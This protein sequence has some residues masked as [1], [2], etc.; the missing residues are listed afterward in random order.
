MLLRGEQILS[1]LQSKLQITTRLCSQQFGLIVLVSEDSSQSDLEMTGHRNLQILVAIF[2]VMLL[3]TTVMAAILLLVIMD[4]I[5]VTP[6]LAITAVNTATTGYITI[7]TIIMS[8]SSLQV[9]QI[10]SSSIFPHRTGS[11]GFRIM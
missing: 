9:H 3:G 11:T 7:N 8:F 4:I 2:S 6:M 1:V 5:T 10:L